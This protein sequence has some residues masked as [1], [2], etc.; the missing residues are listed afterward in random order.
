[1]K[2]LSASEQRMHAS[3]ARMGESNGDQKWRLL[4]PKTRC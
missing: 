1:M 3:N 4:V 2:S